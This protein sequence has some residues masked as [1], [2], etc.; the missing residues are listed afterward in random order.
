MATRNNEPEKLSMKNRVRRFFGKYFGSDEN[1]SSQCSK[2]L[3][4]PY[5]K[6]SD[7]TFKIVK[8]NG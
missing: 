2:C 7:Y 6:N 4:C 1:C 3:Y 8:R 5:V